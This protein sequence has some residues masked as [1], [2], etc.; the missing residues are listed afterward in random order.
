MQK[1]HYTPGQI[2]E[3]TLPQIMCLMS[4]EPPTEKKIETMADFKKV[5]DEDAR[6]EKE[7]MG[8]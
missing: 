6:K 1:L 7:W 3:F 5:L 2:N 8:S 4:K